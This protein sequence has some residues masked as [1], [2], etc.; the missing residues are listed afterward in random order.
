MK[1]IPLSEGAFTVDQSKQFV[2]F[3]LTD[4]NLQQRSAGSLLVEIQPFVVVTSKDVLLIDAGLGFAGA[5]GT[6]QLHQ[7]LISHD[8]DPSGITKVLMSHLHKDHAGGVSINDTILNQR[9]LS[10]PHATYYVQ[11]QELSFALQKGTPSY[12][13]DE[14]DI[15]QQAGNVHFLQGN[16]IIDNYIHYEVTG[17]HSPWHQVFRIEENGETIFYGADDA[18]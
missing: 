11:Q 16:G 10:F 9:F 6:L 8:I 15:L 18:P 14:I 12:I 7:N 13:P 17:G 3:N 5:D 4:D 1:I 2:P